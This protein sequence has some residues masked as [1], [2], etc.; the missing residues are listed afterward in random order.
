L[1]I[2][3]VGVS[4]VG[5]STIG[6]LLAE[7]WNY[8]FIDFDFEVESRMGESIERI[9]N[10]CFYEN[11]YRNKVMHILPQILEENIDDVII[12][13]PPSGLFRE[14]KSTI[15]KHPDILTVALKDKAKNI[16][17]R[18]TFYDEDTVLME[19]YIVDESNYEYYY[20]DVKADIE[21][22]YTTLKKA[23]MQFNIN[24]MNAVDAA[25]KLADSI[26][27][28]ISKKKENS[29]MDNVIPFPPRASADGDTSDIVIDNLKNELETML[30]QIMQDTLSEGFSLSNMTDSIMRGFGTPDPYTIYMEAQEE[31][32]SQK[33]KDIIS[34]RGDSNDYYILKVI[35]TGNPKQG[36]PS[37]TVAVRGLISLEFFCE[38]AI[39]AFDFFVDRLFALYP[40]SIEGVSGAGQYSP[41]GIFHQEFREDEDYETVKLDEVSIAEIKWTSYPKWNIVFDFGYGHTFH[42]DFKQSMDTKSFANKYKMNDNFIIIR[43]TGEVPEQYPSWGEDG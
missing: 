39:E 21:Y 12:A 18:L 9:K 11:E 16:M 34:G 20:N 29:D 32:Y 43:E 3:L 35:Y 19:D 40:R 36:K 31:T 1:R 14:Y 28:Y 25:D 27:E 13:M 8:P 2:I 24:G 38:K 10:T 22:F 5:K 7:K 30:S 41:Y 17:N 6:K 33:F 42:V 23:K 15:D 4:C 26:I 37:R